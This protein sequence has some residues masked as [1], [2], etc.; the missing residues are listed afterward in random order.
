MMI[1][2]LMEI[3]TMILIVVYMV[4]RLTGNGPFLYIIITI[5]VLIKIIIIY[6]YFMEHLMI[7]WVL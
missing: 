2:E 3:I 7:M 1:L 5:T 6:I 4:Q